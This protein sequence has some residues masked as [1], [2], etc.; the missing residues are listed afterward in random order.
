[1]R[2]WSKD[3][4]NLLTLGKPNTNWMEKE[5]DSSFKGFIKNEQGKE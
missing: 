1:M 3:T 4:V 2:Y 5:I